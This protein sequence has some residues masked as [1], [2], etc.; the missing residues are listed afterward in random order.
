MSYYS[1]TRSSLAP[2]R[3]PGGLK[4]KLTLQGLSHLIVLLT[5]EV[6]DT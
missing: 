3:V 4:Q 6:T 1:L 5:S 2:V